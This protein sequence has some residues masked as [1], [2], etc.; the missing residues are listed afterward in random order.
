MQCRYQA[1]S[2]VRFSRITIRCIIPVISHYRRAEGYVYTDK[3]LI[4]NKS[5]LNRARLEEALSAW[6]SSF[7]SIF[8]LVTNYVWINRPK[9][10]RGFPDI[11]RYN[12]TRSGKLSKSSQAA[13]AAS[14][15]FISKFAEASGILYNS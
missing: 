11:K 3:L 8:Y 10:F 9:Y 7:N 2:I 1:G 4:C 13:S 12:D 6:R 15:K 14:V 5:T